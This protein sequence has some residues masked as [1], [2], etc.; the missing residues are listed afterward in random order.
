[1][2][3][4]VLGLSRPENIVLLAAHLLS[5]IPKRQIGSIKFSVF[6]REQ[7]IFI[8]ISGIHDGVP[9]KAGDWLVFLPPDLRRY[10]TMTLVPVDH[11]HAIAIS[12][13]LSTRKGVPRKNDEKPYKN[14]SQL[15]Q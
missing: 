3:L 5:V 11:I 13:Y 6:S 8:H 9:T 4:P 1:V 2:P 15:T 12:E 14:N 10:K 7:I